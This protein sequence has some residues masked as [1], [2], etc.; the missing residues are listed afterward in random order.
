[1]T[2]SSVNMKEKS[3]LL[4]SNVSEV[5]G[6]SVGVEQLDD[7]VVVVFHPAADDGHLALD[8]RD[9]IRHQVLTLRCKPEKHIQDLQYRATEYKS[10]SFSSYG[11]T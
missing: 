8:H 11:I 10:H 2:F 3:V 7:R 4:T 9:I 5:D 6:L 1:M